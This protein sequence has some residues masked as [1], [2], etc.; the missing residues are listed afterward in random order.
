[1]KILLTETLK[2]KG[3]SQYWLAKKTGIAVSTISNLCNG[4]TTSIQF[5]LLDKI[6]K[7]LDCDISEVILPDSNFENRMLKYSSHLNEIKDDSN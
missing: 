7:T 5:S 3:R 6:C 1:M 2:N 4:K